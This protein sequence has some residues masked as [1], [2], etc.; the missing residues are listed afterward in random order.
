MERI[1]FEPEELAV[2]TNWHGGLGSKL[3]AISSVG[4]LMCGTKCPRTTCD[5]CNGFKTECVECHGRGRPMTND[6]WL[7]SIAEELEGEAEEC[8]ADARKRAKRAT[9]R[10]RDELRSDARILDGIARKCR[11]TIDVLNGGAS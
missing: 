11:E 4:A 1:E 5:A 2:A 10:D 8:A 9:R 7:V 6:E 3:Y